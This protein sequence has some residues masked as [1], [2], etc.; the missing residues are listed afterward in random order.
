MILVDLL[1]LI[2]T[3]KV[4]FWLIHRMHQY[5]PVLP[6]KYF[7][8]LFLYHTF[9]S[10]VYCGMTFFT[11]ADAFSY[12]HSSEF[13]LVPGTSFINTIAFLL[14]DVFFLPYLSTFF[15]FHMVSFFWMPIFYLS[16][17]E[18]IINSKA[19][20]QCL[21]CILFLPGLSYWTA[22]IGK[23]GL[24]LLGLTSFMFSLNRIAKR[25][26]W[27]VFSLLLVIFI[28]PHIAAVALF[29]LFLS[30][31]IHFRYFTSRFVCFGLVIAAIAFPLGITYVLGFIGFSV[32][33]AVD[34]LNLFR[35]FEFITHRYGFE[36]A[37]LDLGNSV[38]NI[39]QYSFPFQVFTYL[40]RPLVID[41]KNALQLFASLE[42]IVYLGLTICTFHRYMFAFLFS[43]KS[44]YYTTNL[45]FIFIYLTFMAPSIANL[46]LASRQKLMVV[47]SLVAVGFI[48]RNYER[49]VRVR[50]GDYN[51]VITSD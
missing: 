25:K 37:N 16:I 48:C 43:R 5:F 27:F 7:K 50:R 45:F 34:I 46:G 17:K 24:M 39:S 40:Y 23:D 11:I 6:I 1:M 33:G 21:K 14:S 47:P 20:D 19:L 49:V 13:S 42:N 4:G 18:N 2:I 36:L 35:L 10:L 51:C 44:L 41:A 12:Y 31:L 9:F 26:K 15:V 38:V 28:R 30:I 22:L 29:A 3:T 8:N 32:T